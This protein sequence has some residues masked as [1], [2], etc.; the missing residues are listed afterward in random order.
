[1][2]PI[3]PDP[4]PQHGST[5][6][7]I[8]FEIRAPVLWK[9]KLYETNKKMSD[10]LLFCFRH[11]EPVYSV[12]FSPD[13]KFLASGSFDKENRNTRH[14]YLLMIITRIEPRT[15]ATLHCG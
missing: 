6:N 2:M 14:S 8:L 9:S 3:P 13:G 4:Y 10:N 1:M 5:V 11:K 15:V 7:N 12:A